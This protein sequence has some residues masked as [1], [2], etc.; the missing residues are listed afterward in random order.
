MWTCFGGVLG[1]ESDFCLMSGC[2][3]FRVGTKSLSGRRSEAEVDAAVNVDTTLPCNVEFIDRAMPQVTID[4][5]RRLPMF[6]L[7]ISVGRPLL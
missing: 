6:H 5:P 3:Q 4:K 2:T 1:V 7:S